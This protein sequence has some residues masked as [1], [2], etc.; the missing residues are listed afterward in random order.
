MI[1]YKTVYL[2][3]IRI[4]ICENCLNTPFDIYN[5]QQLLTIKYV[6]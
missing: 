2:I 3:A 4:E 6:K 1:T 5:Q